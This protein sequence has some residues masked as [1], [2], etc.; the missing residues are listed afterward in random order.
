LVWRFTK[1]VQQTTQNQQRN[2]RGQLE[3][4][5]HQLS[6][7]QQP[8]PPRQLRLPPLIQISAPTV[9]TTVTRRPSVPILI[10]DSSVPVG[11]DLKVPV[12]SAVTS[13]SAPRATMSALST[14]TVSTRSVLSNATANLVSLVMV[15]HVTRLM[16]VKSEPTTAPTTPPA[17]TPRVHSPVDA[18]LDSKE[19]ESTALTST[20]VRSAPTTV[21]AMPSA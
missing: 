3:H 8:P 6:R 19:T 21:T 12:S 15:L 10:L 16:N 1:P 11:P 4:L 2:Q 20:N 7:K 14:P 17:S 18:T 5:V 13:T 9:A